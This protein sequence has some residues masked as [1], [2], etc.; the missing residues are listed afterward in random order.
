MLD[1]ETMKQHLRLE[2][3]FD[4]DNDLLD[5]YAGAAKRH[6]ENYTDRTLYAT[7]QQAGYFDDPKALLLDDDITT[8]MLLL[9]GHW[10]ENREAVTPGVSITETPMAVPMLLWPHRRLGV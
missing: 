7:D 10:Y 9:V 4:D 8:A 5:I 6:V 1:L 2:T 3:D